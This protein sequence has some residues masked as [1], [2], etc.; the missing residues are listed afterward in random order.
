MIG[1]MPLYPIV[2]GSS[3]GAVRRDEWGRG[4]RELFVTA[5]DMREWRRVIYNNCIQWKDERK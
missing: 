4:L 5:I 2:R 1:K 3:S